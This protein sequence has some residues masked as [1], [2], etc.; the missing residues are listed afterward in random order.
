[1]D[2][3]SADAQQQLED[4]VRCR[5]TAFAKLFAAEVAPDLSAAQVE[6]ITARIL[7][8]ND[9][10]VASSS[11]AAD[12]QQNDSAT[13][14]P[15]SPPMLVYRHDCRALG[16]RDMEC[17]LCQFNPERVCERNFQKKYLV[18]DLLKAKCGAPIR[19][20]L[21]DSNGNVLSDTKY[22][23]LEYELNIVDGIAFKERGGEVQQLTDRE[24]RGCIKYTKKEKAEPLLCYKSAPSAI[25]RIV[26]RLMDGVGILPELT[27]TESSEAL[28]AGRR[29]PFRL[30]AWMSDAY[31]LLS[32]DVRYGVSNEFVVATR[33]VRQANKVEIP[34]MDDPVGKVEH[35]GRETMKK[36]ADLRIAA[37]E[38]GLPEVASALD[39]NTAR[40]ETVGQFQQLL[41]MADTDTQLR[42]NLQMILKLPKDK[43]EE[44]AAHAMSAVVPDFRCF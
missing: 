3:A 9:A 40:I 25:Q 43:W 23:N 4:Y 24:L 18:G 1:M 30:I 10:A 35:V 17:L 32:A 13:A 20:E 16:C 27:V 41:H 12:A 37:L 44:T 39:D 31:G 11:P 7:V 15:V 2:S 34:L 26:V 42:K 36:L 38:C 28:L 14:A 33:R 22:S 21:V 8:G 19:L 5:I 6:Q 29:P